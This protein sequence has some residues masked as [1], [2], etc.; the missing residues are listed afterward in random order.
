MFGR[1]A[2]R[3]S[4]LVIFAEKEYKCFWLPEQSSGGTWWT[5]WEKGAVTS[6][7]KRY[8]TNRKM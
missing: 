7:S 6:V 5:P 2:F 1:R 3:P 8:G 4:F